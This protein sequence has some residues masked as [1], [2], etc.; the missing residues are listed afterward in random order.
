MR[1]S[2]PKPGSPAAIAAQE[3]PEESARA[4][5][6]RRL[7]SAP[8]TRKDLAEDLSRRGIPDEII[9]RVLD[10]FTE[11]GLIDDAEYARLWVTSRHRSK[12]TA[13][14]CLKHELRAKGI[15]D[16]D[17][18]EALGEIDD[19][20]ERARGVALVRSKMMSTSRLEP[21]ARARRL[22]RMLL[23]RGYRQSEAVSIVKEAVAEVSDVL[24]SASITRQPAQPD[25][26]D[27]GTIPFAV[28]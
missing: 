14:S 12:G 9:E 10:R 2:R 7:A 16:R 8:R 6:L 25:P 22:M 4:T 24:E 13:R 27:Y 3:N 15:T 5:V 17:A 20:A 21:A 26:G 19:D 23:R 18:F 11:V 1:D 28:P